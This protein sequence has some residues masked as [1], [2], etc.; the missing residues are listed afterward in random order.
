MIGPLYL[1]TLGYLTLVV[2][3]VLSLVEANNLREFS[4]MTGRR[5]GKFLLGLVLLGI[6]IQ[7]LSLS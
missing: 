5:W 2:A 7:G 4:R 1:M 6:I 3:V